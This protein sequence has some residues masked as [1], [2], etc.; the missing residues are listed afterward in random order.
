MQQ[1]VAALAKSEVVC[2]WNLRAQQLDQVRWKEDAHRYHAMG[3]KKEI[4][5]GVGSHHES[6]FVHGTRDDGGVHGIFGHGV[7][8][9]PP[10][11]YRLLQFGVDDGN[12]VKGKCSGQADNGHHRW[13]FRKTP[14][15]ARTASICR[16]SRC[17]QIDCRAKARTLTHETKTEN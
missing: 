8:Q 6:R 9:C 3:T 10:S 7:E 5:N 2:R 15:S 1:N 17:R 12:K 16:N 14:S 4:N 13:L 11:R